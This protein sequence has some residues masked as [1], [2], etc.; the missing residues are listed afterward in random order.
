MDANEVQGWV[1]ETESSKGRWVIDAVTYHNRKEVLA[2]RGG[3]NGK[4][5]CVD[6]KGVVLLGTYTD[7]YPHIG[8][9][10]FKVEYKKV[11]ASQGEALA[12]LVGEMGFGFLLELA[13]RCGVRLEFA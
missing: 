13:M 4:F 11:F 7:A 10:A 6:E 8:E 2:Y 9:A 3:V 12:V 5:V 1:A